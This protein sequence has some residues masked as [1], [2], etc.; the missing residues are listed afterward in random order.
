VTAERLYYADSHLCEFDA[1]VESCDVLD[2]RIEIVLDKT[3]FYPTS[4]GQP[5]DTGQLGD[6]R[7]VD[8]IDRE[9][10][11]VAHVVDRTVAV[12]AR[13][14]G[15]VDWSRRLDHLQQHTGQHLLSAAF[16]RECGVATV[17]FH[18]GAATSTID[19]ARETTP[20][21]IGHAEAEAN[22]IVWENRPVAVRFAG[23]EEAA[24]LPLRKTS[25]RTGVL[26]L[27]EVS[28]FDLSAC[29]GTH[30]KRTGEVGVV[31][32]SGWERF[33][34]VTRLEFV[35]GGRALAAFTHLRDLTAEVTGK[36][37]VGPDELVATV[38]R[39]QDEAKTRARLL[40]RLHE[41]VAGHRAK[42]LG[43]DAETIGPLRVVL[44]HE[45]GWDMKALRT[46]A[47]AVVAV[48]G[49]VAVLVGD[50]DPSPVVL[51]RSADLAFDAE[52]WMAR[53]IEVRGG[54]GGGRPELAQGGVTAVAATILQDARASLVEYVG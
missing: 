51:A 17:S 15:T 53:V 24:H 20:A 34:G 26:R 6:A 37:S 46:L 43:R 42:E 36:L 16:E 38:A 13:V 41:Q 48:P 29:G 27:V 40:G 28:D 22:R 4:G 1:V 19:L 11:S 47:L 50:G 45:P 21:E 33:K 52:A 10:G 44:R 32:V 39:L 2:G 25:S 3:A 12:G 14:H 23:E 35:C 5:F 49:F 31:A 18:L 9:D 7:V 8:V 54:R 30:A